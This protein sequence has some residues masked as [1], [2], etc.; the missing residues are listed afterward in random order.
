MNR[1]GFLKSF[2][3]L[4]AAAVAGPALVKLAVTDVDRL[5]AAMRTGLIRDQTF[6]F[7]GPITLAMDNLSILNCVFIFEYDGPEPWITVDGK[8][9]L[10]ANC[11][12]SRRRNALHQGVAAITFPGF[13]VGVDLT[14]R[15]TH[16]PGRHVPVEASP[17]LRL[18]NSG[19]AA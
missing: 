13:R 9:T 6:I 11:F 10:V 7:Q 18:P 19:R 16:W 2:G 14:N 5:I 3:A 4:A 12:F 1:R 17:Q 15:H 8:N